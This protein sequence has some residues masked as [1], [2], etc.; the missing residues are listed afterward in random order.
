[1]YIFFKIT[2][3]YLRRR[4]KKMF[5]VLFEKDSLPSFEFHPAWLVGEFS[6]CPG[7]LPAFSVGI[8]A[9]I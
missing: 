7:S 5:I 6:G 1:M 3:D 4:L 9:A 2:T 8:A